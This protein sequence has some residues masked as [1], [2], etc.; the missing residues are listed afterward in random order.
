MEEGYTSISQKELLVFKRNK[1]MSVF[2]IHTISTRMIAT[3]KY[4]FTPVYG[5]GTWRKTTSNISKIFHMSSKVSQKLFQKMEM[6]ELES[7]LE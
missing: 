2:I 1:K 6:S 3:K 7:A 4:L 5:F